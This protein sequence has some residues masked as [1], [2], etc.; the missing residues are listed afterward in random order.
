MARGR[1]HFDIGENSAFFESHSPLRS[2]ET[3]GTKFRKQFI[4]AQ[5]AALA[6]VLCKKKYIWHLGPNLREVSFYGNVCLGSSAPPAPPVLSPEPHAAVTVRKTSILTG[7]S[8]QP[9]GLQRGRSTHTN[10]KHG[11]A[12]LEIP[13]RRFW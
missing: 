1:M 5:T 8:P 12:R 2:S 6:S 7:P 13:L 9:G 11:T 3:R 10:K 4:T